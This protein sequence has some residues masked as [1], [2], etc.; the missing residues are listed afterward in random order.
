M[1]GLLGIIL[2]LPTSGPICVSGRYQLFKVS[3][4]NQESCTQR[5]VLENKHNA[6]KEVP[7]YKL[8]LKYE[9]D[10]YCDQSQVS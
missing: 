6:E 10:F 7:G 9:Q 5:R 8:E 1:F 3:T 4:F 2:L